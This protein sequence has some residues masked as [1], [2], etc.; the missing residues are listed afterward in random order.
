[1]P[2]KKNLP[3]FLLAGRAKPGKF[4]KKKGGGGGK[5][6]P[7]K[8]RHEHAESLIKQLATAIQGSKQKLR[9]KGFSEESGLCL[10]FESFSGVPLKIESLESSRDKTELLNVRKEDNITKA[11]VFIPKES[12]D[13]FKK[14]IEQY[15][16]ENVIREG[17]DT[18]K[19]KNRALIDST[20]SLKCSKLQSLWVSETPFPCN[21]EK[22]V[23]WEIW[24]RKEVFDKFEENSS[25]YDVHISKEKLI[26][27]ER[28][29]CLIYAS[30]EE[31][32]KLQLNTNCIAELR[33]PG[34][35]P[36]FF[37]EMKPIEQ[38]EWVENL[39]DRITP[40]APSSPAVC[41]LDTGVNNQHKLLKLSI[42]DKNMHAYEATWGTYD[43]EGHGTRM[44]GLALLGDLFPLLQDESRVKLNHRLESVKIFSPKEDN[45]PS[46]YG[47]ITKECAYRV[48]KDGSNRNRVFCMAVTAPDGT[49]AGKPSS[50]S[51]EID[52]L[53]F[54]VEDKEKRLFFISAGNIRDV[55]SMEPEEYPDRN[56]IEEIENPAQSWNALTVGAYTE[57]TNFVDENGDFDGWKVLAPLG[58]LCPTSRTSVNWTRSQ[59]PI[60][61]EIVLEGGNY[62][63]DNSQVDGHDELSLLTTG[64]DKAL[65]TLTDTSAATAQAA[66]MGAMLQEKYP[67]LWPETIRGLLVHSAAWT[68]EM[69]NGDALANKENKVNLLRR[70]GYGVPDF[71]R[72]KWSTNNNVSVIFQDKLQPYNKKYSLN[73]MN[74]HSLPWPEEILQDI[75]DKEVKIRITLSYFIEPNPSERGWNS[76]YAYAS[77]G[78]RFDLKRALE[79]DT[80]FMKRVNYAARE[81]NEDFKTVDTDTKWVLGP[82]SRNNGSIISD[83]W[84][85]NAADLAVQNA[86]AIYP[87]GGWWKERKALKRSKNSIRY[88]LIVSIEAPA[89]DVDIYTHIKTK[90]ET[91]TRI[92]IQT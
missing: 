30:S 62:I 11:T 49:V 88:S 3:H 21:Y 81:E 18:G 68:K 46:L 89:V 54:G 17:V 4:K 91:L 71:R 38:T 7:I 53:T 1:M 41:I 64:K 16:N 35:T 48:E 66:R 73:E 82:D 10:D 59:W 86:L 90:I 28:K 83:V 9:E 33:T 5:E 52:Q 39:V 37:T 65:H 47:F 13:F 57:K 34:T 14:K 72:A 36:S 60:K 8:D 76:K 75:G 67:E 74:L 69:L 78:L 84:K 20:S 2:I 87:I 85:G 29:V 77:H 15:L 58:G 19:P 55:F 44:A 25:K 32:E 6:I 79:K 26:F 43:E 50:W 70:Y 31:L 61:P 22:K 51:A 56:D 40:A 63:S 92:E 45:L 24:L 27:P 42:S 23:W 12:E 80:D